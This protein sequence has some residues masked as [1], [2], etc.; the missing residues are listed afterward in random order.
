[1]NQPLLMLFLTLII[2]LAGCKDEPPK[3]QQ[4]PGDQNA[5]RQP[6]SNDPIF[7]PEVNQTENSKRCSKSTEPKITAYPAGNTSNSINFLINS[8]TNISFSTEDT[9]GCEF[10]I[11]KIE[12]DNLPSGIT[13][14]NNE[15]DNVR[16][17]GTVAKGTNSSQAGTVKVFARNITA[18]AARFSKS[19]CS[20]LDSSSGYKYETYDASESFRWSIDNM[21][22]GSNSNSSDNSAMLM[23][24]LGLFTS[25][26]SGESPL[27]VIL[28]AINN[29]L[30]GGGLNNQLIPG[31]QLGINNNNCNG[32]N[33]Q[34]QC[35]DTTG[36]MWSYNKCV[37]SSQT[38]SNCTNLLDENKCRNAGC[39]WNFNRCSQ[40]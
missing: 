23:L 4:S 7:R 39:Y 9:N 6:T 3:P 19:H 29:P 25:L 22:Q 35:R 32:I 38:G 34:I 40:Q 24:G 26:L 13:I 30:T 12:A 11:Y 17:S 21:N 2:P 14:T 15:S 10:T 18:C 1:M 16:L 5:N 33:Q 31:S 36:C 27:S 28:S 37:S 8:N 20:N